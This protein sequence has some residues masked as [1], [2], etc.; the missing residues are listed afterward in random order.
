MRT[1]LASAALLALTAAGPPAH[2]SSVNVSIDSKRKVESCSDVRISFDSREALRAEDS[3]TL[4]GGAS[5][6]RVDLPANSS[7]RV[8]GWNRNEFEVTACKA[9]RGESSLAAIHV[10]R[11]G[12]GLGVAGPR[13]EDW[14]VFLIVKA[15]RNAALDLAA[16][17]GSIG[18]EGTSG[19]LAARTTNGPIEITM[20]S[21]EI[22]ATATNGPVS[23]DDCTGLGEARAV[24][25]PI[26]ISGRSGAYRLNT[27]N[28]P[29]SVDLQGDR[30]TDGTLEAH[31]VNGPLTLKLSETYRSGV[32]VESLGH[33]PVSCPDSA[34][35]SAR[36]T[37]DDDGRRIEFG[38]LEPV[39]RLSTRNGP[40]SIETR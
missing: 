7:I 10:S 23:I 1:I 12:A 34:C 28:G 11:G 19:P 9:A 5:P 29:I 35:R 21:G 38:N 2:D 14:L 36:R 17:N 8:S 31:A 20:S 3:L 25:G 33:G 6:F 27:E 4:P 15:P 16:K 18:V 22:R 13:G 32:I 30:W 26:S 39:V 24:N 37:F 40:V